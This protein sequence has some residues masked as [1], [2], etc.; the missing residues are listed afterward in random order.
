M[1]CERFWIVAGDWWQTY[2]VLPS[3]DLNKNLLLDHTDAFEFFLMILA[4]ILSCLCLGQMQGFWHSTAVISCQTC[5]P[6]SK[7]LDSP[8]GIKIWLIPTPCV[9]TTYMAMS[10]GEASSFWSAIDM[11]TLF[12]Y[13]FYGKDIPD[14]LIQG[15]CVMYV[16][17]HFTVTCHWLVTSWSSVLLMSITVC[18][19]LILSNRW[20]RE[21]YDI[22]YS[23]T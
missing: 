18:S 11:A 23:C 10:G 17:K 13:W 7:N 4:L 16:M 8:L 1:K 20:K 9:T 21:Q 3:Q 6:L 5:T 2:K 19:S 12:L 22:R 14:D 15:Q